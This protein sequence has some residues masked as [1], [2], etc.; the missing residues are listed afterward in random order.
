MSNYAGE[1]QEPFQVDAISARIGSFGVR[2]IAEERLR[3]LGDWTPDHDDGHDSSELTLAALYYQHQA[4][5]HSRQL[6]APVTCGTP[7]PW[8][9]STISPTSSEPITDLVKAGAL[10]AAEIDRLEREANPVKTGDAQ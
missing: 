1:H 5:R 7:P 3:Q 10:I 2:L 9:F 8:P 6:V 4:L